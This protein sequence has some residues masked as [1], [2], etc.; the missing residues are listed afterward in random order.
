VTNAAPYLQIVEKYRELI[1]IGRLS[2]GDKLPSVKEIAAQEQVSG[3]TAGKA[4]A[5]LRRIGF[6]ETNNRGTFVT[7]HRDQPH[8][9]AWAYIV[10]TS[11]HAD[12]TRL[13]EALLEIQ[14]ETA[15][16]IAH[17]QREMLREQ[18]YGL[19]CVCEGCSACL[20]LEY[21]NRIDPDHEEYEPWV[22]T[23]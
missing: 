20:A 13:E 16:K 22:T 9:G 11:N 8:A 1:N 21:I 15:R 17:R 7:G 10:A 6:V 19:D 18:G 12:L 14:A 2:Q 3:A 4:I 5:S 23:S